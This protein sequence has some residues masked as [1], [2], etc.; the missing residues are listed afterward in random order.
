MSIAIA[1]HGGA[2]TIRRAEMTPE[3]DSATRAGLSA[4]LEAGHAVLR[5]GGAALDAVVAAVLVLENH[6]LFNAGMAPC[7]PWKAR[8]NWKPPSWTVPPGTPAR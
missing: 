8:T 5:A 6:P 4:A 2:G 1:I 3:R 7:S